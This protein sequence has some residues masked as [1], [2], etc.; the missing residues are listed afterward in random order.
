VVCGETVKAEQGIEAKDKFFLGIHWLGDGRMQ[1]CKRIHLFFLRG[2]AFLVIMMLITNK[3]SFSS[4]TSDKGLITRR[5][6]RK[7]KILNAQRI[8]IQ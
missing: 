7:L 1:I 2:F 4:C 8:K 6:H 3:N 5:L